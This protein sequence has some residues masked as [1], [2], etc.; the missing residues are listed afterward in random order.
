M[1]VVAVR[2]HVLDPEPDDG[3][4]LLRNFTH[5]IAG[6]RGDWTMAA[7]KDE[8]IARIDP[9]LPEYEIRSM[10]GRLDGILYPGN[11]WILVQRGETFPSAE[12][13]IDH[14]GWRAPGALLTNPHQHPG[15][16]FGYV[17]EGAILTSLE[18]GPIQRYQA[19][20]MFYEHRGVDYRGVGADDPP[21]IR[22]V[23]GSPEP[24]VFVAPADYRA[25]E[26][27]DETVQSEPPESSDP[28]TLGMLA[29]VG[30][31]HGRPFNPDDRMR[32]LLTEMARRALRV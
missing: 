32:A 10:R 3:A 23:N 22:F 30:I 14:I 7:F 21:P 28:L 5:R 16:L 6:L 8:A 11:V 25:W 17:L 27:L 12:G 19:G 15:E 2:A 26:L 1:H 20:E 31:Q 18:N 24:M 29:S 9:T 13:T 4:K